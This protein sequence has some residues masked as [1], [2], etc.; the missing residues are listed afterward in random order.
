[1][2]TGRVNTIAI[3]AIEGLDVIFKLNYT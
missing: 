3:V 1:M 2:K